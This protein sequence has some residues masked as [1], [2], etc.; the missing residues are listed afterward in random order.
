MVSPAK[1]LEPN[2]SATAFDMGVSLLPIV[3]NVVSPVCSQKLD[4]PLNKKSI[5]SKEVIIVMFHVA[6]F[7]LHLLKTVVIGTHLSYLYRTSTSI[8]N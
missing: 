4:I 6:I 5:F 7:I 1:W 8:Y 3:K 2:A